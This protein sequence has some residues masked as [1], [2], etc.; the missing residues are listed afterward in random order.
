VATA[1]GGLAAAAL[2]ALAAQPALAVP[3]PVS[4][5]ASYRPPDSLADL[6]DAVA[7]AVVSIQ[8]ATIETGPPRGGGKEGPG[9]VDPFEFFFGPRDR[10][11]KPDG[12]EGGGEGKKDG[13]AGAPGDAERGGD[14]GAVPEE[15][16]SDAGGSGF[17]ISPEGLVI[18]NYHVVEGAMSVIVHLCD[19]DYPARVRGT[20]PSTDLALLEITA[21]GPLPY[22]ALGDSGALRVGD[23]VVV[24]GNPLNLSQTVTFGMVSA[25][26]R[27]IGISDV[28]FENFIQTDAAINFGNS[29]GPLIDTRGRV[30]GIA[31]AINYGAENIG[32]AVPVD[33]LKQILPQLRERGTVSR[34][35]LGVVVRNLTLAQAGAWGLADA[36]GALVVDVPEGTPGAAG[37]VRHGDVVLGVD[38]RPVAVTKDL[39][40]YV[41][42]RVPGTT[43]ALDL[44][45]DGSRVPAM[46]KLAERPHAANE[47]IE[48]PPAR[49]ARVAKPAEWLGIQ[50][51][52]LTGDL[53]KAHAIP[54]GVE[55]LLVGAVAPTSPLYDQS[56]SPGDVVSE[57]NG[58]PVRSLADFDEAIASAK[59][60]DY[61]RLYCSS[62]GSNGAGPFYAV[63]QKPR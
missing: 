51:L 11:A 31:T 46:V 18:T 48:E 15:R 60:G 34:G 19:R 30:V 4:P 63:A 35:Y 12:G 45:R 49:P 43:V 5:P 33:T 62:F 8:A 52:P 25:K 37:G 55:G 7:P 39:I 13:D 61:V 40:D 57:V 32:F 44:W 9:S 53:R 58:R 50:V 54:D 26:G 16:R 28:S 24:I 47:A 2:V 17:V 42:S 3:P 20:D 56:V 27:S 22:L 6:V 14:A 1:G 10:G 38:G 29:G 36:R 41:A 23:W 59:P 21:D